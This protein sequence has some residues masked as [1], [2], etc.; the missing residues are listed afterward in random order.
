MCRLRN[1]IEPVVYGGV[2]P[3]LILDDL[4]P[5]LNEVGTVVGSV[6]AHLVGIFLGTQGLERKAGH[7]VKA[8]RQSE[9]KLGVG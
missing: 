1:L 9:S 3:A 4:V 8:C 5:E 6:F 2:V 7:E